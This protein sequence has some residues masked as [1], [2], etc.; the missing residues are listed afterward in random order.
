MNCFCSEIL[1]RVKARVVEHADLVVEV[2]LPVRRFHG[3]VERDA[4]L[5]GAEAQVI[6]RHEGD[7]AIVPERLLPVDERVHL[8]AE[9]S[10]RPFEGVRRVEDLR[11]LEVGVL[12]AEGQVA[13]GLRSE[14]ADRAILVAGARDRLAIDVG[15]DAQRDAVGGTVK[16]VDVRAVHIEAVEAIVAGARKVRLRHELRCKPC[17]GVIRPVAVE[18]GADPHL[19]VREDDGIL[20]RRRLASPAARS[21]PASA[22]RRGCRSR[23]RR[24]RRRHPGIERWRCSR[25]AR[26]PESTADRNIERNKCCLLLEGVGP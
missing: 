24:T 4:D 11:E 14:P 1:E 12:Q 20:R 21:T 6:P 13:V 2:G 26:R 9:A 3:A 23:R 7:E 15:R 19:A 22:R 8:L 5:R 10:V 25:S 17:L 16:E 18:R